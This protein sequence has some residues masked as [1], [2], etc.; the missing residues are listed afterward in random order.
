VRYATSADGHTWTESGIVAPDPDGPGDGRWIARGVFTLNGK[1]TALLAYIESRKETPRGI[2][3]WPN[4]RLVRYEWDGRSWRDAG[5]F[6]NDCM[7]NYPPE[8]LGGQWF[9]TCRDSFRKMYYARS[10][11]MANGT[12]TVKPIPLVAP[13]DNLSEPSG[14]LG[15]D[16]VAH[17]LFRD[18]GRSGRLRHSV[19]HDQG[20]TWSPA[21][22][23]NYPDATSKNFTGRLFNG[24][25]YLINNPD[26]KSRDPLAIAFSRDGWSFT[27]PLALRTKPQP[28]RYKGQAK[29]AG[30]IQYPHAIEHNG[31]LWVIYS[32]NKEDI[33]ITE[34]PLAK[35]APRAQSHTV[36][37]AVYGATPGGIAAALVAA[38][39]GKSVAL[40]EYR[41]HVGGMAASGLGKSDIESRE[42]I[43]GLFREFTTRVRAD[44][45]TRYG[46]GSENVKLSQDGY[47]Y[48]PSVAERVFNRMIQE[49][50]RI[51]LFTGHRLVDATRQGRKLAAAR[52]EER[53]TQA[54]LDLRAKV[55]IDGSYEGDLAAFAGAAYRIGRE[56]RAETNELHAGV[57]YQDYETRTFLPGTSGQGDHRIQ[58]YTYRLCLTTDPGN[59]RPLTS[60]PPGYDRAD[61]LGYL[62]DWK[63]GRLGATK[64]VEPARGYYAPTFGTLVRAL[65]M[66][67]LPNRKLDIN[68]NPRPLGFPFAEINYGYPEM[69]W[70]EREQVE[71]RIRNLTIGLLYFL[72]NDSVVPEEHRKLAQQFHFPKDEF[73]DTGGF[74]WQ[75]YVREGRRIEGEYIF[76]EHDVTLR[77]GT[78]RAPIHADSIA[79]ADFPIDSFPV[80]KRES[81]ATKALEG[82]LLMLDEFTQPYQIP[83]RAIVPK[84]VDGLLVPVAAS[85]THVAF[86]TIRMEPT[87]MALGQAAGQ[88]AVQSIET[89][90]EPR[91]VD[92]QLLQR[93]LV[94]DGQIITWF[95]D[96]DPADPA[97]QAIQYY[98]AK[99]F[100]ETY[101]ADSRKPMTPELAR[102]WAA[103]AGRPGIEWRAET[104]GQFCSRLFSE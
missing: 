62:D 91:A 22:L 97:H 44:Y 88:A 13:G 43:G 101:S 10:P 102:D 30:S 14:Y 6:Q 1:L 15:P 8:R 34:F 69:E 26:P 47:Y 57:V 55:F 2:D 85:S 73:N 78:G 41:D 81:Q 17:L 68:M 29:G 28:Q 86:S 18:Q 83:Y 52:F 79:A 92:I 67:E 71:A 48:E 63:A 75:L 32:T 82:Y 94:R 80:R 36:D 98:G 33:E 39:A 54:I 87:W 11:T 23:T 46:E 59:S 76:S 7:N 53:G 12:W 37:V 104:R 5:L 35:L 74:P 60:P 24:W 93:K 16:G 65:S 61:Y 72:Q 19:S 20:V 103:K 21:V 45:A 77:P 38:R 40:V 4:L 42:T 56:S 95:R 64:D 25:Y 27:A 50:G 31:S 84:S 89:N 49:T 66:A 51:Q 100:F 96:I 99:G 70:R 58:A 3:Y 9:M 90:R